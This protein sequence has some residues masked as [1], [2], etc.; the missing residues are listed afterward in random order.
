[1]RLLVGLGNPW[2]C[3]KLA[4]HNLGSLVLEA[5]AETLGVEWRWCW[6]CWGWIAQS[7]GNGLTMLIPGTFYNGSGWA[8]RRALEMLSLETSAAC[9]LH[10]DIDL[11]PFAWALRWDETHGGNRGVQSVLDSTNERRLMRLRVG[12]ARPARRDPATV[13]AYVLGPIEDKLLQRW[14]A[15]ASG[16]E[17]LQILDKALG[18][19]GRLTE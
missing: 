18:N 11:E 12:V 19:R 9:L 5:L 8:V 14:Q 1:M 17:L 15:A 6:S 4:R 13:A 2:P 16:G 7:E 10:D 3:P